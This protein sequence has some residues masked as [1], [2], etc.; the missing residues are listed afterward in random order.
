LP[1]DEELM[2]AVAIGDRAALAE[3]C[4]R[5]ERP[6]HRFLVRA[7]GE[8]DADDLFQDTWLRVARAARTFDPA[9]RFSTWLYQIALNLSRDRARRPRP[10]PLEPDA[11]DAASSAGPGR[12]AEDRVD[13]R[14]DLRTLLD[15]LPAAQ[16]EVVLLRLLHDAS[17]D[18]TADILGCPPG[19]VKSRLHHA[20]KRLGALAAAAPDAAAGAEAKEAR[21]DEL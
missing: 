2:S 3:L 4:A 10:E 5:H 20:L 12:P 13:A 21:D 17:E 16:R 18:E 9:R 7:V 14:L 8:T 15:A 1:T 6:L 11:L 19:T